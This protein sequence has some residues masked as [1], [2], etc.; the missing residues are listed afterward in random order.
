MEG[1]LVGRIPPHSLEMEQ[2]VLGAM[3]LDSEA[4]NTAVEQLKIEDFYRQAH[5]KIFEA[6]V[7]LYSRGEPVDMLL[8]IEELRRMD[9]L[10]AVG[11]LSYIAS[12]SGMVLSISNISR[13]CKVV[14]EKAT[15]RHL[16]KGSDEIMNACFKD[17]DPV[18]NV[19]E[20]AEQ[21]VFNISQHAHSTEL[22]PI[23]DVL[24]SNYAT[25]EARAGQK[26]SLTG[27]TTG[28]R[29]L[30]RM[31]SGLQ[32]SDLILLAARP[33]MGKTALMLNMASNAAIKGEAKVAIFSLEMSKEQLVQRLISAISHVD[34]QSIITADLEPNQWEDI[35]R[36]ITA[37][38]QTDIYI[39]DTAGITP[40]ELKAKC[41]RMKAQHGLDL[42]VLDYLQLMETDGRSENRQQEITKISRQLKGI[43]KE[44]NVPLIALSQLSRAPEQRA[45]HR[46]IMSDL[47]E[48]GAIEQDADIVMMLFRD[49]VYNK[50]TAVP[51][52]AELIITKHRNGPIGTVNLT[53]LGQFTK[54][55]NYEAP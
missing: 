45:D 51:G 36:T 49:E 48:S 15:L 33:S 47:R 40:T 54:F 27:V 53:F 34:L 19:V 26:G 41:R 42:I 43:A 55:A 11:G 32:K 35:V 1:Q 18:D 24:V 28:F 39:D 20:R 4:I 9:M 17:E 16:I 13:Y 12:L 3:L 7:R 44:L 14:R 8:V 22:T 37:L 38:Q 6:M 46:P 50:E 52:I 2:S 30:D 10:E 23:S 5:G 31:I 21:I 29:D 25:M